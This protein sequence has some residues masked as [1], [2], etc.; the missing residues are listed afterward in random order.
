MK[1]EILSLKRKEILQKRLERLGMRFARIQG[2]VPLRRRQKEPIVEVILTGGRELDRMKRM[3]GLAEKNSSASYG[4]DVLAFPEP[5]NFPHPDRGGIFLG[6]VYVN[7]EIFEE[8]PERGAS[9]FI[10]G[11]LH[12]LGYDHRCKCDR[13]VMKKLE[14][15]LFKS[16]NSKIKNQRLK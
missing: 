2:I 4:T 6:E 11:F 9:L 14:D 1:R 7:Q 3:S 12:L 15:L 13:I 16:F 10:H 5:K 8:D